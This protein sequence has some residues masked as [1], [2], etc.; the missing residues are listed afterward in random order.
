MKADKKI[1]KK[2][3]A[4]KNTAINKANYSG[5]YLLVFSLAIS[6]IVYFLS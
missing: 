5:F 4:K 2:S 6:A 1:T 3:K